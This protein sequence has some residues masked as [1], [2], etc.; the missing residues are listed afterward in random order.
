MTD[1]ELF[2]EYAASGSSRAFAEIVERYSAMVYSAC[3]RIL[4]NA[5][6]AEDATQAA[7]LIL[8][9]KAKKLPKSTVLSGWL[10]LTAQHAALNERKRLARRARHERKAAVIRANRKKAEGADWSEVRPE[11]DVAIAS[12]PARQ[13]DA[14]VLYYLGGRSEEEVAREMGCAR[15]TVAAHL[16]TAVDRLR[17]RLGRRGVALPAVA[18]AGFLGGRAV[19]AAPA[20]L[21]ESILSICTGT[22]NS[23]MA[24]K[25]A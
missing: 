5:H 22:A 16:S 12:L 4:G 1:R 13:R 23:E 21:G 25:P 19:E 2:S 18:L 10:F 3:L 14:V 15:G 20:A 8:V 7:F 11:L 6:A 17:A 24:E 9:R